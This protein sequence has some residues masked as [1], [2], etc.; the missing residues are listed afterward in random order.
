MTTEQ[1]NKQL[2]NGKQTM[3]NKNCYRAL[4]KS[5]STTNDPQR[6]A[7]V[8]ER[9]SF[10]TNLF[11][12]HCFV[13]DSCWAGYSCVPERP[14]ITIFHLIGKNYFFFYR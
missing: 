11:R 10:P 1:I 5:D 13:N 12:I 3:T 6:T 8:N 7:S 9:L 4:P 14:D 2:K